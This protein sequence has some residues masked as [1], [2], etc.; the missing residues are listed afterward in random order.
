MAFVKH[1][2]EV[3]T[4]IMCDLAKERG[5]DMMSKT[6][7][8]YR[9]NI[10]FTF[11]HPDHDLGL[12]FIYTIGDDIH[13]FDMLVRDRIK[14]EWFKEDETKQKQSYRDELVERIKCAGQ[15]LIDRAEVF[16][17]ED[18]DMIGGFSIN[19]DFPQDGA[20]S[21]ETVMRTFSKNEMDMRIEKGD[22]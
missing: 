4:N 6:S 12:V 9:N 10:T 15:D 11:K 18:L 3:V 2:L 16:V 8:L 5:L 20:V 1:D 17:A 13:E 19:I 22:Y 7:D 14:A 21:I